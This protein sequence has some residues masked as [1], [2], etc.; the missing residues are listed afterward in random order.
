MGGARVAGVRVDAISYEDVNDH[1]SRWVGDGSGHYIVALNSHSVVEALD[2]RVF[3]D[4]VDRADLVTPDGRPLV[5]CLRRAGYESQRST[6]G[7]EVMM[8][9][10]LKAQA[11]GWRV[12]LYGSTDEVLTLL[13]EK[14]KEKVP[15]VDISYI[16][17]PPFRT[18]T[19]T[20]VETIRQDIHTAGVDLLFVCLGCPN[21]EKWMAVEVA[22]LKCVMVGVGAAFAFHAGLVAR[23]PAAVQKAGLE[24]A[25]RLVREPKRLWKRYAKV[26]PRFII[27]SLKPGAIR[28]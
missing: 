2:S 3:F 13:H 1:V 21:Q 19:E 27:A 26:V 28:R 8:E 6:R 18:L 25:Y 5:W 14:L 22:H 10:L 20:E 7:P 17:S 16:Y 9:L 23:A 15:S 24:W 12:G 4:A 11:E